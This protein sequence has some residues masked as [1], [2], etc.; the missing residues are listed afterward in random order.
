MHH[1]GAQPALQ[2]PRVGNTSSLTHVHWGHMQPCMPLHTCHKPSL[3]IPLRVQDLACGL[4]DLH[5]G[6]AVAAAERAVQQ[7]GGLDLGQD[8]AALAAGSSSSDDDDDED[9]DDSSDGSGSGDDAMPDAGAPQGQGGAAAGGA[10]EGGAGGMEVEE[11]GGAGS[12]ER[13]KAKR[14]TPKIIEL[15]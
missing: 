12:R 2:L 7:G 4:F 1:L 13:V 5:D 11:E 3:H 6:A 15:N 14:G 8:L 10:E 9:D